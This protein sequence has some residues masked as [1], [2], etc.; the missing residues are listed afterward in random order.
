M[1][2][3]ISDHCNCVYLPAIGNSGGIISIWR[4]SISNLLFSFVGEGFVGVCL[5]WGS[6]KERCFVVNIY[7]KCDF[8][9]NQRLWENIVLLRNMFDDGVWCMVGDFN[10]AGHVDERREVNS[11]ASSEMAMEINGFNSFVMN[12]DL[13]D[14]NPL[15]RKFM[16]YHASGLS[17]SRNDRV[18]ISE[19][20]MRCWGSAALWVLP[21]TISDHCPLVLKHGNTNWGLK[22]FRFNNFW[23]EN[24]LFKNL[25]EDLWKNQPGNGWLGVVL[26]NKIKELKEAIRI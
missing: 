2:R 4:K 14:V 1:Y 16:W 6:N 23:L 24:K 26:K 10:A 25:V 13:C 7:S 19:G 15:G 8:S 11:S 9:A 22:P 20:W 21:R 5:E 18:L 17:M 12:V 3:L